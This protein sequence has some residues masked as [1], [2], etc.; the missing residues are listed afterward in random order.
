MGSVGSEFEVDEIDGGSRFSGEELAVSEVER[1]APPWAAPE[2]AAPTAE[3]PLPEV[4]H[5]LDK[6]VPVVPPIQENTATH[7]AGTYCIKS[8]IL[9][10]IA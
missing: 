4:Y 8:Y 3:P 9:D 5:P 1:E 6:P 10:H 7:L 2:A